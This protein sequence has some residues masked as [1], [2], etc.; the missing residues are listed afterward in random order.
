MILRLLGV[1]A[2]CAYLFSPSLLGTFAPLVKAVP[3]AVLASLVFRAPSRPGK[4]AAAI[5]LLVAALADFAIESSFILGLVTFLVAHL[6]Y[7]AAFLEVERAGRWGRLIP[8][9]I[10]AVAALPVLASHAGPMAIPVLVYGVVILTMMWRAAAAFS[11]W[12]ANPGT[13]GLVGALLFGASDTLL[14]WSRFVTPLPA[15]GYLIMGTYW[16]AQLLIAV[17]FLRRA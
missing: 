7:I 2:A 9:L 4:T 8:V 16:A 10:W 3:V 17:S 5:G 13:F 11:S 15:S 1:A 14:A 6:F 12:G